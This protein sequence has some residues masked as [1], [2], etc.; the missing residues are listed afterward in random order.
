MGELKAIWIK[1]AKRGPMDARERARL[2][3]GRGIEGN[4]NQGG[5]RQVTLIDLEHHLHYTD[6]LFERAM[7]EGDDSE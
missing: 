2:I 7:R 4:A 6:Q 1:R 5:R 3:A